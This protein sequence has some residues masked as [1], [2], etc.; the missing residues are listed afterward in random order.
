MKFT[1]ALITASLI[2]GIMLTGFFF[3]GARNAEGVE[4]VFLVSP[5][6]TVEKLIEMVP[7]FEE[8]TGIKVIVES[9]SYES[10]MEKETLDLRTKQGNY[11]VFWVEATYL[12]RYTLCLQQRAYRLREPLIRSQNA[13]NHRI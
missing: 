8:K 11:D 13:R 1:K 2:L 10:M 12:E 9:I 6:P 7:Q 5:T 4:I 3:A